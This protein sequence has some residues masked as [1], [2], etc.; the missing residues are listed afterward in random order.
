MGALSATRSGRRLAERIML[1]TC[2]IVRVTGQTTNPT[3]G[4]VTP[5]TITVYTGKCR[6]KPPV[7][8]VVSQ[9]SGGHVAVAAP[10]ELH[11]PV[12]SYAAQPGDLATITA[13]V[14]DPLLVG[15]KYRIES[16]FQGSLI[17]AYRFR[18]TQEV[19]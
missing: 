5:T 11:I 13:A 10:G 3:T 18:I 7:T 15:A 6:V 1:D 9:E 16:P 19:A 14:G 2:T 4:A 8:S 12:G 17:T